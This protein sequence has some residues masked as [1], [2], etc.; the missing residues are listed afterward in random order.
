MEPIY[1]QVHNP[2][3]KLG[4]ELCDDSDDSGPLFEDEDDLS[5]SDVS[6]GESEEL[7]RHLMEKIIPDEQDITTVQNKEVCASMC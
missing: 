4:H 7:A 2:H 1:Y 5:D 3:S 6:F